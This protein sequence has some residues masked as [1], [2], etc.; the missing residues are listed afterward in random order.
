MNNLPRGPALLAIA[1][2]TLLRELR[3]LVGEDG[4]YALAMVANAMAIAARDAEA[5]AAPLHDAAERLARLYGETA[6]GEEA[7][8]WVACLERRLAAEIRSGAFDADDDRRR[9]VL[10]HLRRS[11]AARL[12]VSNPKALVA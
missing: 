6:S 2:E 8:A 10:D 12:A 11:V 5:G 4:R 1:R 3:P 9:L 7:G